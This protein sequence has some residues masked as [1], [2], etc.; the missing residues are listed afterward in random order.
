MVKWGHLFPFVRPFH[1][2]NSLQCLSFDFKKKF[3]SMSHSRPVW[4]GAF[5]NIKNVKKSLFPLFLKE[6][7][8]SAAMILGIF[9]QISLLGVFQPW[10]K[11]GSTDGHSEPVTVWFWNKSLRCKNWMVS[12]CATA[13][14]EK[15]LKPLIWGKKQCILVSPNSAT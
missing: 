9:S 14:R 5:P 4:P 7:G 6:L 2:I 12:R 15:C 3:V 10:S 11:R 1:G 13:G 8:P